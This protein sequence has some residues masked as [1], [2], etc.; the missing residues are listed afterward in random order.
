MAKASNGSAAP[1]QN[2][3]IEAN[4]AEIARHAVAPG[5]VALIDSRPAGLAR[6]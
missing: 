1:R 5:L 3:V 2:F 4:A 6:R